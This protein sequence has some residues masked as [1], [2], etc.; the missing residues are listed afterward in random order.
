MAQKPKVKARWAGWGYRSR[1]AVTIDAKQMAYEGIERGAGTRFVE[2]GGKRYKIFV[3]V[4]LRE[5]KANPN[6]EDE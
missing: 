4:K 5:D 1:R 6:S 3:I 2:T